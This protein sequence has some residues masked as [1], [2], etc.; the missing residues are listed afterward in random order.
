M[1]KLPEDVDGPQIPKEASQFQS[2]LDPPPFALMKFVDGISFRE[3]HCDGDTDQKL[4]RKP[5]CSV[6]GSLALVIWPKLD[7]PTV[8]ATPKKEK[9]CGV[10]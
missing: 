6:R 1:K 9:W 4:T 8:D 3:L 10:L 7:A 5:S 2:W